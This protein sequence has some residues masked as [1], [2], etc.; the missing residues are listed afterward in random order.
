MSQSA[1]RLSSTLPSFLFLH[2][3]SVIQFL[4]SRR[5]RNQPASQP[6]NSF[7]FSFVVCLVVMSTRPRHI[8]PIGLCIFTAASA[9]VA[10]LTAVRTNKNLFFS[11]FYFFW[12]NNINFNRWSLDTLAVCLS[13]SVCETKW[14]AIFRNENKTTTCNAP[15]LLLLYKIRKKKEIN[16]EEKKKKNNK[17]NNKV[18]YCYISCC[19][20]IIFKKSLATISLAC[21]CVISR[22]LVRKGGG[23]KTQRKSRQIEIGIWC[24][25]ALFWW[26]GVYLI[27]YYK[28]S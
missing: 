5:G 6:P 25:D 9:A 13:L 12:I 1:F 4:T 16:L 20:L 11:L 22:L 17:P 15:M 7:F 8:I 14:M 21:V 24:P 2:W 19:L 26:V 10:F 3:W 18:H 27:I 28:C 23:K